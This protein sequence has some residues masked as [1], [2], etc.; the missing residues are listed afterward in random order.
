MI[1][2]NDFFSTMALNDNGLPVFITGRDH[3]DSFRLSGKLSER[4][5]ISWNYSPAHNGMPTDAT[6]ELMEKVQEVLQHSVEQ[7][8]LAILTG[9]YTGAG[10]RTFVFYTRT[11]HVFGERLNNALA[12]F[13]TL[14][15]S[16][17]VEKDPDWNEYREMCEIKPFAE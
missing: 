16:I 8:K 12:P 4:V 1:L 11:S 17:Y 6:A 7:D 13:E 3:I 2:S 10:E 9:I 14:P 15:I 5:E